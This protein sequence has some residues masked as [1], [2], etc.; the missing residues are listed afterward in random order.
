MED[1]TQA[2]FDLDLSHGTP[3]V[4]P[5]KEQSKKKPNTSPF[6]YIGTAGQFGFA[7]IIPL[8]LGLGLGIYCDKQFGTKPLYTLVGL[9]MGLLLSVASLIH[10]V[11]DIIKST[12]E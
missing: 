7:I 6:F 8:L 10:T 3:K 9:V 2:Q 5:R 4:S 11:K 1:N 12:Q